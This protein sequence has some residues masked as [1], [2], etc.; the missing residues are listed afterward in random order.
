MTYINSVNVQNV[1]QFIT[2]QALNWCKGG[3]KSQKCVHTRTMF[4][5]MQTKTTS[6]FWTKP[7]FYDLHDPCL[8]CFMTYIWKSC[9][10]CHV[11]C[12]SL[13]LGRTPHP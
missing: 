2:V 4:I 9:H 3:S 7:C 8:Q 13:C 5:E 12:F 11:N 10:C 1:I 6:L